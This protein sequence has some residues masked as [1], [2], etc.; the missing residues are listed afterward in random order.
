VVKGI[1]NFCSEPEFSGQHP[2]Q[3]AYNQPLTI[4]P[5]IGEPMASSGS[6]RPAHMWHMH[7]DMVKNKIKT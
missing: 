3:V 6:N 7:G 5:V 1:Y 4:L 2:A